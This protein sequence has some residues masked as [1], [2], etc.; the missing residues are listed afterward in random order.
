MDDFSQR[1]VDALGLRLPWLLPHVQL[2][3]DSE[4]IEL[5]MTAPSGHGDLFVSTSGEEVTV[6]FGI[7]HGHFNELEFWA[8]DDSARG[9]PFERVLSLLADFL[10][11]LVVIQV[12]TKEGRYTSSGPWH[13]WYSSD[14][15]R[16]DC[17]GDHYSMLSWTGRGDLLP[18]V[19][20]D[21]K[22][23]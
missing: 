10:R 8:S 20:V 9:E 22:R 4:S 15:C 5:R 17:L 13:W 19:S 1:F 12:W 6:G 2:A 23:R 7:W 11:D 18:P 14:A 21:R 3:S 16:A